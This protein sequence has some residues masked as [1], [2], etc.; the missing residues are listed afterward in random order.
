MAAQILRYYDDDW[1]SPVQACPG[2]G[3]SGIAAEMSMELYEELADYSC[4]DCDRMLLVVG[5]PTLE[6]IV[7]AAGRG[8]EEAI[9][10]LARIRRA[11]RSPVESTGTGAA[12]RRGGESAEVD[13]SK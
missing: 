7:R 4:P 3:W 12:P 1:R 8:V 5:H 11:G 2:C 10:H 9:E 6:E 13:A